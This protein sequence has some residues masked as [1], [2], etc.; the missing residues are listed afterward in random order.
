[1]THNTYLI[2]QHYTTFIYVLFLTRIIF[3][4]LL[5]HYIEMI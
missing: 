4:K 1:M 3:Y 5:S 2:K